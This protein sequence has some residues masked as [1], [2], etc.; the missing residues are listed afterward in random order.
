MIEGAAGAQVGDRDADVVEHPPRLPPGRGLRGKDRADTRIA[1]DSPQ[2]SSG[3]IPEQRS[4]QSFPS[5]HDN[6]S[7]T[8]AS[9]LMCLALGLFLS[10]TVVRAAA[11]VTHSN[12]GRVP[13]HRIP[14][15]V[16]ALHGVVALGTLVA[17]DPKSDVAEFQIR[18]GWYA[19]RGKPSDR[20]PTM[21]KRRLHPGLWKVPLRGF[22][23]NIE[24]Y[25]NG[26]ASGIAHPATLKTW[27]QYASAQWLDRHV[28]SRGGLEAVSVRRSH[29][30]YLSR[31]SRLIASVSG[32]A[33][34]SFSNTGTGETQ[35]S[36]H[37]RLTA[38]ARR[39]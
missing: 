12:V 31:R 25:P 2:R 22:A 11:S 4:A 36:R 39:L 1:C 16:P 24:T 27:E 13:V 6:P 37:R 29:D 18:C 32:D 15:S 30:R 17:L 9:W 8:R 23:F 20:Q 7:V 10:V 38:W 33:Q 26:P 19:I 5:L 21:P 14:T 28:V 3:V 34:A 35:S